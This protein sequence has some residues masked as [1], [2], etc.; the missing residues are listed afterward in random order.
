MLLYWQ[1]RNELNGAQEGGRIIAELISAQSKRTIQ[2]LDVAHKSVADYI[3][4]A[5]VRTPED[6]K[7]LADQEATYKHLKVLEHAVSPLHGLLISDKDGKI[8]AVSRTFL[9]PSQRNESVADRDY[10]LS[11]EKNDRLD[12]YIDK[13][14]RNRY[15]GEWVIPFAYRIANASGS[16][17][18]LII[19]PV[20]LTYFEQHYRSVRAGPGAIVSLYRDDGMLL[21]SSLQGE[22]R[23]AAAVPSGGQILVTRAVAETPL[24]VRVSQPIQAVLESWRKD[25]L[26]TGLIALVLD[27]SIGL[28]GFLALRQIRASE[29]LAEAERR[30]ARHDVLTGLPNRAFFQEEI[31]RACAR[32]EQTGTPFALL[33]LDVDHFKDVNDILGHQ[34]GDQL[35]RDIAVRLGRQTG[36]DTFLA[37][38]GGDEFAVIQKGVMCPTEVGELGQ[39]L[40]EE[41]RR[42]ITLKEA[43]VESSISIGVAMAPRDGTNPDALFDNADLALYQAKA[44]GRRQLKHFSEELKAAEVA[45]RTF[46]MDLRRAVEERRFEVFFQPILN[47]RNQQLAGF[48]ALLRWNDP[49][50]GMVSPAQF[51][52]VAEETGLIVPLG[53]WVLK[54]ACRQ[55]MTWPV[56]INVAV[57]LSPI[58]MRFSDMRE[59][60]KAALRMSALPPGRLELEITESVQLD[61]DGAGGVL[62]DLRELGVG[63]SLDDFGTGYASLSYL[64]SFPFDRIKID[65]SF[66]RDM[67]RS[68]DA[69]VIV[70]TVV[71]LASRMNIMVTG[72]GVETPEQLESLRVIGCTKAQGYLIGR[73]MPARDVGRFLHEWQPPTGVGSTVPSLV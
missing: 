18:G 4:A 38:L 68:A 66:V 5:G 22:D 20:P 10:F 28:A 61:A 29:R 64:R 57:N 25:A 51:I 55:A 71:E 11:L 48:E 16:F 46:A 37:R 60:V 27:L 42:L 24:V 53:G 40:I 13:T 26:A 17:L 69:A 39:R 52:P 67:H 15:N 36:V 44:A 49:T 58:Q 12:R 50:R 21:A 47:L 62:H 3:S 34:A 23:D 65:Q 56:G 45:K 8:I 43:Q 32:A 30:A 31:Q 33:L 41:L 35:L 54:E 1:H 9:T 70:K 6:L 59:Q 2:A 73:P 19:C 72:E 7:L 63:V 14:I